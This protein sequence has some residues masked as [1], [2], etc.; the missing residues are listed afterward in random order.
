VAQ[1]PLTTRPHLPAALNRIRHRG[2]R[3]PEIFGQ[4]GRTL[5]DGLRNAAAAAPLRA[6]FALE[7]LGH[8]PLHPPDAT[9][10]RTTRNPQKPTRWWTCRKPYPKVQI[11]ERV[12]T[13]VSARFK[14]FCEVPQRD[15]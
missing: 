1:G 14:Q 9:P 13:E 6:A 2:A 12:T 4:A 15:T 5:G 10:I 7:S 8:D 11:A 3:H